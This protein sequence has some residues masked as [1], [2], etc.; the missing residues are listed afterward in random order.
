MLTLTSAHCVCYLIPCVVYN[1][2]ERKSGHCF[3]MLT[4]CVHNC[5]M[6]LLCK[7]LQNSISPLIVLAIVLPLQCCSLHL[8]IFGM[9]ITGSHMAPESGAG[10]EVGCED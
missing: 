5:I 9:C 10:S 3:V 6:L 4:I 2:R 7:E 1:T 8:T